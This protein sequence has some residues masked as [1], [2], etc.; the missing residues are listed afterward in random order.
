MNTLDTGQRAYRKENSKSERGE[1][2]RE[3]VAKCKG[4]RGGRE[5]RSII[6]Y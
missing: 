2:E 5:R 1:R 3:D 4:K 6:I